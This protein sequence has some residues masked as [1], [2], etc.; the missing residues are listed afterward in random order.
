[1]HKPDGNSETMLHSMPLGTLVMSS[2]SSALMREPKLSTR[3]HQPFAPLVVSQCVRLV[4]SWMVTCKSPSRLAL[5]W[6]LW[7]VHHVKDRL[8]LNFLP[9]DGRFVGLFLE[10]GCCGS[11]CGRAGAEYMR[12]LLRAPRTGGHPS[13][14]DPMF[15]V[16]QR[17]E[18]ARECSSCTTGWRLPVLPTV[19]LLMDVALTV[20]NSFARVGF[21]VLEPQFHG[22]D[23]IYDID[24]DMYLQHFTASYS[25]WVP[26]TYLFW[27]DL[28]KAVRICLFAHICSILYWGT[29]SPFAWLLEVGP[30]TTTPASSAL[31][32]ATITKNGKIT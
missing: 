10:H 7:R 18:E 32:M 28:F 15:A 13:H 30:W 1:M 16:R 20:N 19:T 3:N 29:T 11:F 9:T 23:M 4:H 8:H 21:T 12:L 26:G 27:T 2:E 6:R 31:H 5:A 25:T 14:R 24:Y 17:R 22:I